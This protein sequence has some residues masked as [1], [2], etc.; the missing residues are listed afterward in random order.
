MKSFEEIFQELQPQLIPLEKLRIKQRNKRR[1]LFIICPVLIMLVILFLIIDKQEIALRSLL[2]VL[3]LAVFIIVPI[4]R[5]IRRFIRNYAFENYKNSFKDIVISHLFRAI[6]PNLTYSK[7]T[8]TTKEAYMASHIF[9]H[10]LLSYKG[11]D[12]VT[13]MVD[14]TQIEL[15][16]LHAEHYNYKKGS[17]HI[18]RSMYDRDIDFGGLFMIADFNKD[19]NGS[20]VVWPNLAEKISGQILTLGENHNHVTMEDPEFEK[21]FKA[22]SNDTV[23]SRYVLSMDLVKRIVE[24]KKRLNRTIYISFVNS[25]MYLAISKD[26]NIFNPRISKSVLDPNTIHGHY[27]KILGCLQIVDALDLNTRIWTKE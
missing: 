18:R 25:K 4:I 10:R 8:C 3:I 27:N 5:A 1:L 7:D 21:M 26:V 20:V 22:F 6:N 24:L 2:V 14:K 15:S 13:G 17:V 9:Q 19:F 11:Y 16:V 12:H 23:E